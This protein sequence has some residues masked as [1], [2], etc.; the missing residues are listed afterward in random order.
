MDFAP[1]LSFVLIGSILFLCEVIT[2]IYSIQVM[3]KTTYISKLCK[4]YCIARIYWSYCSYLLEPFEFIVIRDWKE[5]DRAHNRL[6]YQW[7]IK[8]F[9]SHLKIM[10]RIF[11]IQE[12]N[13]MIDDMCQV[14]ISS[15]SQP[16]RK[17]CPYSEFFGSLFFRIWTEYGDL[18]CKSLY[19]VLMRGNMDQIL[20][21]RTFFTEWTEYDC[22]WRP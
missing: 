20:R 12:V 7:S 1:N 14:T 5:M 11:I 4:L 3:C 16:L 17:N 19:S 22:N 10:I 2:I 9:M 8:I 13:N 6:G 18:L 21:I 15:Q